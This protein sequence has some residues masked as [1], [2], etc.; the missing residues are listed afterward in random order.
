MS[1]VGLSLFEWHTAAFLAERESAGSMHTTFAILPRGMSK[2][3]DV[4]N[5]NTPGMRIGTQGAIS[6]S[7]HA[8]RIFFTTGK[9]VVVGPQPPRNPRMPFQ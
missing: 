2:R 6:F 9:P 1:R 5:A 8:D 7:R 4:V 3:R